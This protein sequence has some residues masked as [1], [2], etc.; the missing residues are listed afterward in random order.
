MTP[1]TLSAFADESATDTPSQIAALLEAGLRYIDVRKLDGYNV[2]T[3]P[4]DHA[5]TVRH[6]YDE[7]GI[8]VNMF[9]SPIGKTDIT[10]DFQMELDRLEHLARLKPILGCSAVRMFSFH[11][12][13]G[14]PHDAWRT[15]AL[16]RLRRLKDRAGELG[17]ILYHENEG[18]VFGEHVDDVLTIAELRDDTF[19]LIYDFGN[20]H[21]T[22]KTGLSIWQCLKGLTDAFHFKDRSAE[23]RFVPIGQGATDATEIIHDAVASG[24]QGPITLEPH[25]FLNAKHDPAMDRKALFLEAARAA[26][27]LMKDAQASL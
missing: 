11:N 27:H 6:A 15:A 18:L 3:L 2:T 5:E 12:K 8:T 17:L 14:L 1:L 10:D 25:L 19:R 13:T 26:V 24:W 4:L 21:H 7:A 16:D 23:G 22:G 9:G 20:H